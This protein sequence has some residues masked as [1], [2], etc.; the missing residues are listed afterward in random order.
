MVSHRDMDD[1]EDV[2]TIEAERR[3]I[4][5]NL[6]VD[7]VR[8]H[9]I[10]AGD[11]LDRGLRCVCLLWCVLSHLRSCG[12]EVLRSCARVFLCSCGLQSAVRLQSVVS[13]CGMLYVFMWYVAGGMWY[14]V[15]GL[16]SAS[17]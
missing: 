5:A 14:V 16:W 13:V 17:A 7:T 15:C 2:E 3:S 9:T 1:G 4:Y 10:L 11:L 8:R 6:L 12:L